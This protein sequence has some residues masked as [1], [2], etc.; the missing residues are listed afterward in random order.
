MD[1]KEVRK[2]IDKCDDKIV[3]AYMER[4]KLVKEVAKIKKENKLPTLNSEREKEIIIR[5]TDK[6]DDD[7]KLYTKQVFEKIFDTAKGYQTGV[8]DTDSK[9]K[10]NIKNAIERNDVFPISPI[11]ACQGVPGAYS[12][13]A[14]EKLFEIPKIMY[15]KDWN[16]VFQAVEKGLCS[17]GILPIE[18]STAGSVIGVYDLIQKHNSYI[19]KAVKLRINHCLMGVERVNINEIKEIISHEQALNQCQEFIQKLSSNVVI[20]RCDNTAQA[21]KI[22]AERGEKGVVCISSKECSTI[23]GLKIIDN[24]IQNNIDNYTRFIAVTKDLRIFEG[25]NKISILV[26]LPH[27]KGSLNKILNRFSTLGLNLTKLES[28]PIG[29]SPFEFAFYFDFEAD[30]RQKDVQNLLVELDGICER[31]LF[32]GGYEELIK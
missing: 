5:V 3:D 11:V 21:A 31:F 28:R 17:Y 20:T 6:V 24:N 27:E 12:M 14:A 4:M 32:L 29:S 8:L 10:E 1:L 22:V 25:A 26:N 30:I 15:F 2:L 13:I 18:N 7:I 19:V 16:G 23:Y 9:T